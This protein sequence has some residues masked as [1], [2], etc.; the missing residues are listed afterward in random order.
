MIE[1][2]SPESNDSRRELGVL[3]KN[4]R[5][6]RNLAVS[7][8]AAELKVLS[9]AIRGLEAGEYSA[10]K[11]NVFVKGYIKA[12]AQF[13]LLDADK[14]LLLYSQNLAASSALPA[15][16]LMENAKKNTALSKIIVAAFGFII[17]VVIIVT[18]LV[19]GEDEPAAS[20]APQAE[21]IT[22]AEPEVLAQEPPVEVADTSQSEIPFIAQEEALTADTEVDSELSSTDAVELVAGDRDVLTLT[23]SEDC[24]VEVNDA[25]G[26]KLISDLKREGERISL[27]GQ[28]PY[29]VLL[30]YGPAVAL[31][32]NGE[33]VL[34][35]VGRNPTVKLSV[36]KKQ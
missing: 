23:F 6:K 5:E 33:P 36:G 18:L 3:F 13:L 25:T 16:G 15:M 35:E 2:D 19:S 22:Q 9:G 29:E 27:R 4:A 31:S 11:G 21:N 24:W 26:K 12:Y 20:S 17:A 34:F 7:D 8:V 14:C 10:I 1:P 28:P 30:G 32:Y